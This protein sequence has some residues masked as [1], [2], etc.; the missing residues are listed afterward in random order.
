[1]LLTLIKYTQIMA[2]K[3]MKKVRIYV[4]YIKRWRILKISPIFIIDSVGHNVKHGS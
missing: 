4:I 3:Y 2:V 1:M